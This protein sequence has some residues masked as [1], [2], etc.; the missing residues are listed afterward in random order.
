MSSFLPFSSRSKPW[1]L[2]AEDLRELTPIQ[3][4][5]V[6]FDP[7][8]LAPVL[9]LN[10]IQCSLQGLDSEECIYMH[11]LDGAHWSGGVFPEPLPDGSRICML[12]PAQSHRRQKITL[13][14]EIAHCFLDHT[15]TSLIDSGSSRFRDFNK[16]QEQEA[17]GVGAA[18]LLPWRTLF[19]ML[20]SGRT[21][22]EIAEYFEVT[23]ELSAYRI[24]ICGAHKLYASRQK[25]RS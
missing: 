3:R 17:F 8:L 21:A 12:N 11:E 7:W 10:V 23:R 18:V 1:E 9:G 25:I 14:E 13:M 2:L 5:S 4:D 24:Q 15:P 16:K 6:V 20:N 19:P 22:D